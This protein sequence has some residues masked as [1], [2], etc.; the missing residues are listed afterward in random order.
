MAA[1]SLAVSPYSCSSWRW[2]SGRWS[3]RRTRVPDHRHDRAARRPARP[4]HCAR[5]ADGA[6]GRWVRL[7]RGAGLGPRRGLPALLRRP[8]EHG[9]PLEGRGR[10]SASSSSPAATPAAPPAAASPARTAWWSTPRAGSSS[11]S[12]ATAASPGYEGEKFVTLADRYQGKRFNSPNDAVYTSNGDLY[13]TDPPYGLPGLN[14]DPAKEL[15][16]NG[17]YR[18]AKDG[19]VTLLTKEMTFP[20]GIAFS[21]DEKTLYVANSDP[22]KA[23]WMAFPVNEDGTLGKGRVF[24]D[25]TQWVGSKKGLP[26]GMKVDRAGNLFATGP[27]GVLDLRPRRLPPRHPRHRRGHRQLRLGR[28]RLD[29]LHHGRHVPLP[30]PA[31][32][33]GLLIWGMVMKFVTRMAAGM[34]LVAIVVAASAGDGQRPLGRAE[35]SAPIG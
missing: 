25:A 4:H 13:F 30:H 28:R 23:I 14:A 17:V 2:P 31:E 9:L 11:A 33:S 22:T 29:P 16:F 5:R 6:A 8:A 32:D 20:N 24:F 27:G 26:D 18:V 15:D 10:G 12:T 19:T 34:V 7:V 35:S 21:P 3:R 1:P